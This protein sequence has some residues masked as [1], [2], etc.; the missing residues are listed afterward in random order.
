M[1][2]ESL[3]TPEIHQ[4]LHSTQWPKDFAYLVHEKD[5]NIIFTVFRDNIR[6]LPPDVAL[7]AVW[8]VKEVIEKIRN[9]GIPM[10]LEKVDRYER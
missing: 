8:M 3:Y 1:E 4:L 9:S 5:G 7:R 6:S 10:V 2:T